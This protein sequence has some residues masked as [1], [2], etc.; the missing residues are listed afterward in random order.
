M[1]AKTASVARAGRT[2]GRT[3]VPK[4]RRCPAPSSVA[5]SSSSRGTPSTACRSRKMP[6]ADAI[7]GASSAKYVS[8]SRS[9]VIWMNSGT[10]STCNGIISVAR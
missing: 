9:R 4:M 7:V 8:L 1:N 10:T 2:S 5:A 3:T 6:N